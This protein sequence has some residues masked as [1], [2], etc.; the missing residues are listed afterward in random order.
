MKEALTNCEKSVRTK[1]LRRFVDTFNEIMTKN[2][3]MLSDKF[4]CVYF[5]D[6]CDEVKFVKFDCDD[7][8]YEKEVV[9]YSMTGER[10]ASF[11]NDLWIIDK[12]YN[13]SVEDCR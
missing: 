11:Y 10:F 3:G 6:E 9:V 8:G 2:F 12:L 4:D 5:D 7:E 13:L 1:L